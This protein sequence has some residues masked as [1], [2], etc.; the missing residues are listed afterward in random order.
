MADITLRIYDYMHR[1][2]LL[3]VTLFFLATALLVGLVS[4]IRFTED[5]SAFLPLGEQHKESL[6]VYQDISGA[7]RLLAIF[8][9][10][11]TTRTD[12]EELIC[13]MNLFEHYL[14]ATDTSGIIRGV[15]SQVDYDGI[16]AVTDFVYQNIPLFLTEPDY[17][18][19]DSLLSIPG[20]V[21][22]QLQEDLSMLMFPTS[23]LMAQNIQRDPLNL[24]SPALQQL[25]GSNPVADNFE[26]YDGY[27]FTHDMKRSL[28]TLTSPYGNSETHNN[29]RLM[30]ML[31]AVA[32][33][34]QALTPTVSVRYIGGPSIAVGN[35]TQIRQDSILSVCLAVVLILALLYYAFRSLRNILLVVLSISWGW[36][37]ALGVLSTFHQ[38]I[39]LIVVGISSIIVGIAVNYPLHLIAHASHTRDMR[40]ALSEIISPLIIGNITTVG[41]FCALIP[42]QAAALRDLGIFSALLLIGTILFVV[43]WLP[44]IVKMRAPQESHSTRLLD[45]IADLNLERH[46]W[47]VVLIGILTL[48]FGWFSLR[49]GFDANMNHIN[50]MTAQQ[51]SDM[52]F[53]QQLTE[54]SNK[55]SQSIYVV[56]GGGSISEALE[57]SQQIQDTLCS[58]AGRHKG[59]TIRS[60]NRFLCSAEEQDRRIHSWH[61]F[62]TQYKQI[63]RPQLTEK[64]VAQGF[65]SDAFEPFSQIIDGQY[66]RQD[67]SYFKPLQSIYEAHLST[68]SLTGRYR[69]ITAVTVP[70]TATDSVRKEIKAILPPTAFCFDIESLNSTLANNLTDNFNYVGWACALIVFLFLWFSFRNIKLALL[71]FLPMTVS[72]IWIL[73]IMAMLGI[74]F[75]LVNVILATFIFGQGDD[76]TIFVTEGCLYERTHGRKMLA[77][78]KRSIA[79]SALIM[80]IGIGSLIFAQHPALRSLAEVTIVGMFSVVLM[81]YVIPPLFLKNKEK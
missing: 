25:N 38:N 50:Y 34:V 33:S 62:T 12:E 44:H 56:T 58:I 7:S 32:D 18:R 14:S 1:H 21:E 54:G 2:T 45:W 48:V 31:D 22:R 42:L 9:L 66:Q 6:Q 28:V 51:R 30:Q 29:T 8:Q 76:Y 74:Q 15:T 79:L 68:D 16:A 64:A 24:F 20:Y 73:G 65:S 77:A 67:L 46:R 19:I 52:E 69:I 61:R 23:G 39:S 53:L 63:L 3:C 27:I 55:G 10:K 36:L 71:T 75:N 17:E 81:A 40:Q 26:L 80:F 13:A 60:C 57:R 35:S 43:L 4:R 37:F 41:A 5:I 78:H 11:D 47:A 72:W 59:C 70:S 49:T